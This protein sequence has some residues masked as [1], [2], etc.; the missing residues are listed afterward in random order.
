MTDWRAFIKIFVITL[1]A[2]YAVLG[3]AALGLWLGG[4]NF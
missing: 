1:I 3:A 4:L 2:G